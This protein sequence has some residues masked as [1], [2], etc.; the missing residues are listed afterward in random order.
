MKLENPPVYSHTLR[1]TTIRDICRNIAR[2]LSEK[3]QNYCQKTIINIARKLSEKLSKI[4]P[5]NYQNYCQ[6]PESSPLCIVRQSGEILSPGFL[7]FMFSA[8]ARR[9]AES[10]TFHKLQRNPAEQSQSRKTILPPD[11]FNAHNIYN[12]HNIL[13]VPTFS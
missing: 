1:R 13:P 6:K 4:L 12:I 3:Y 7:Y 8:P 2:K 5:E 11:S 10:V 9:S